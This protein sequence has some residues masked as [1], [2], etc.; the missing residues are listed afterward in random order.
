M[1]PFMPTAGMPYGEPHP[2]DDVI[3]PITTAECTPSAQNP[4]TGYQQLSIQTGGYRFPTCGLDYTAMFQLMAQ[5]VI[6]GAQVACEFAI[7]EP[8]EGETLDLDT[9]QVRYSSNGT[10]VDTF[11]QAPSLAECSTTENQF[12]IE[13]EQIKLCPTACDAVQTDANAAIDVLYGC[14]LTVIV[15]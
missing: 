7:P 14:D 9:V 1:E 2:P 10:L 15:D 8:P 3:A 6:A 4:G 11:N 5:G 12:Y 13:G